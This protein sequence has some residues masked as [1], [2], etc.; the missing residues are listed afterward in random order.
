WPSPRRFFRVAQ[1]RDELLLDCVHETESV[2]A[3][4][5]AKISIFGPFK[6]SALNVYG[7]LLRLLWT[8]LNEPSCPSEYPA[9]FFAAKPPR[10]FRFRF[11]GSRPGAGNRA[12]A[13]P[14]KLHL[15]LCGFLH[16]RSEELI[17]IL[18]TSISA[19]D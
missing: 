16:G 6:G 4:D 19:L 18:R 1:E 15:A 5:G 10:P 3:G 7:A 11:R 13:D 17:A 9:G 14:G 12:S 2:P 8:V